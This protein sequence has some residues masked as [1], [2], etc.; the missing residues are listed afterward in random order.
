VTGAA[1]GDIALCGFTSITAAGWQMRA[2]ITSANTASVTITNQTG[3]TVDLPSGTIR[4][5]VMQPY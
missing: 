1:V 2:N 4:V 5:G 3:G